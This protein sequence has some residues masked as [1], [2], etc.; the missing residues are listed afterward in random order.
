MSTNVNKCEQIWTKVN[1]QMLTTVNKCE[2]LTD[3]NKFEQMLTNNN[4]W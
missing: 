4:K 2:M 1:E 3:L